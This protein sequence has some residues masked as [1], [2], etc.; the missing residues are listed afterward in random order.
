[1][2]IKRRNIPNCNQW[3]TRYSY[4]NYERCCTPSGTSAS[5]SVSSLM[6]CGYP[7]SQTAFI[8]PPPVLEMPAAFNLELS[9][10]QMVAL[11]TTC[12][13]DD[14]DMSRTEDGT[15]VDGNFWGCLKIVHD[16]DNHQMDFKGTRLVDQAIPSDFWFDSRTL[17]K[18][19]VATRPTTAKCHLHIMSPVQQYCDVTL[20][21]APMWRLG[22]TWPPAEMHADNNA[23]FFLRAHPSGA[24]E[25]FEAQAVVTSLY[26]EAM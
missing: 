22:M 13:S 5:T 7:H 24:L 3:S 19:I 4:R 25:H 16:G 8:S 20:K 23:K 12:A 10:G 9:P 26:Y 17:N 21:L 6:Y 15:L 1:M 14:L 2:V 11:D 18:L